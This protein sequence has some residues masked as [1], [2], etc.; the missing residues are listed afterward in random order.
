MRRHEGPDAR[1]GYCD[2]F[3]LVAGHGRMC[4]TVP[5]AQ[6]H[7]INLVIGSEAS[8]VSVQAV[9]AGSPGAWSLWDLYTRRNAGR[10]E[11]CPIGD[12]AIRVPNGRSLRG[13]LFGGRSDVIA[14][15]VD[16]AAGK[17]QET[18]GVSQDAAKEQIK[19]VEK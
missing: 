2:A 13:E 7:T 6:G 5:T 9:A 12:S 3:G 4:D 1:R 16:E 15:K 11:E 18:Y 10:D 8:R 19:R 14:G 17:I